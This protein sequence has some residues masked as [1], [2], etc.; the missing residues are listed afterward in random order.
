MNTP[1]NKVRFFAQYWGQE[2]QIEK[3]FD[4]DDLYMST[5]LQGINQNSSVEKRYLELKPLSS[6][7]EEDAIEAAKILNTNTEYGFDLEDYLSDYEWNNI[8]PLEALNVYDYLRS[9]GYAVPYLNY[10]VE[11]LIKL[12]WIRL[13]K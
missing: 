12:G 1:E 6:I 8:A 5:P 2:I 10:S 7:S 13:K 3:R 9:K 4:G 11:D